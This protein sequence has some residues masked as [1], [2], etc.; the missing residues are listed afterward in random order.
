MDIYSKLTSKSSISQH[1]TLCEIEGLDALHVHHPKGSA[2]ITLF[3]A[4]VISFKP[5]R[6]KELIWMSQN[7]DLTGKKAIRGGIPVCWPWFGKAASPSHGFARTSHWE[8]ESISD[9]K[10]RTS[11]TLCL[12]HCDKSLAIWPHKFDIRLNVDISESLSVSLTSTNTGDSEWTMGG[13]L[14]TYLRTSDVK[15]TSISGLGQQYIDSTEQGVIKPSPGHTD[16]NTETDRIYTS[17]EK[18]LHIVDNGENRRLTMENTGNSSAVV[19]N[20][21]QSLSESMADM[22]DEGYLQMVCVESAIHDTTIRLAPG[23]SH[24]LSTTINVD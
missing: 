18:K 6:R 21:W 4:H 14:H 19:W 22:T 8:L 20:P 12:K 3:G 10:Q 15:A 23:R 24:N 2:V 16:I 17:A 13:A 1:V 7:A 11:L 9:N 5:A